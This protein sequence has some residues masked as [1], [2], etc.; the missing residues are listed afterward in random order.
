MGSDVLSREVVSAP[1][2]SME[3]PCIVFHMV[4]ARDVL[5]L[6]ALRVQGDEQISVFVMVEER[7]VNTKDVKRA[8]REA[9]ISAKHMEEESAACGACKVQDTVKMAII[10]VISLLEVKLVFALLTVHRFK[11]SE[12]MAMVLWA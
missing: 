6:D 1:R 4:V 3:V 8:H 7:G 9:L 5:S 10:L 12:S 11:T 2:V